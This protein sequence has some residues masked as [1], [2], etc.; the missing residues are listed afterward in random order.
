MLSLKAPPLVPAA[1]G[2]LVKAPPDSESA[3]IVDAALF[4]LSINLFKG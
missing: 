1:A 3:T 2:L 4:L